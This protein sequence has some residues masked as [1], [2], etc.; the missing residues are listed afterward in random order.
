MRED[1]RFRKKKGF[2]E[3]HKRLI[4]LGGLLVLV[5]ILIVI[6]TFAERKGKDQQEA[7]APV[8][9][10]M[11]EQEG[12]MEE[13]AEES[14]NAADLPEPGEEPAGEIPEPGE[15]PGESEGKEEEPAGGIEA[16]DYST[17]SFRKDADPEIQ[18]LMNRYFQARAMGD[19][20]EINALY[21]VEGVSEEALKTQSAKLLNNAKY[22]SSITD[23]TTYVLD[24]AT[25][26]T[27]LV[28]TTAE[29]KF[30]IA[31]VKTPM[32]MWCYVRKTPEGQYYLVDNNGLSTSMLEYVESCN[33]K[34]EVR[35]LAADVNARMK[36]AIQGDQGLAEAY[37]VLYNGAKTW[38]GIRGDEDDV[39]VLE[40]SGEETAAP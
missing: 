31:R 8:Q 26:D 12:T 27:W 7:A 23:V 1:H 10:T 22:I 39:V 24:G 28:Y 34:D 35:R 32:I 37:G 6:I 13:A 25:A 33:R 16:A 19:A 36:E 18:K 9:Q 29:I 2:L 20:A 17:D 15:D 38:D 40:E 3:E 5:L 11:A 21:G 14:V 4:P 30:Y